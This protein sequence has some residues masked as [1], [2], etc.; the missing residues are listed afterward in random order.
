MNQQLQ[1]A[2]KKRA[3]L[4]A[5]A[6]KRSPQAHKA[7]AKGDKLI[8]KGKELQAKGFKLHEEGDKLHAEAEL[9]WTNAVIEVYGENMKMEWKN[10]N[11]DKKSNECHL[12][13][14]EVYKP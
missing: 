9:Q 6:W 12:G 5:E 14:G 4:R 2:W 8:A 13:N 10:W 7:F 11:E 1:K 3:E